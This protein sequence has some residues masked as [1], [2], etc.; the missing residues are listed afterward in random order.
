MERKSLSQYLIHIFE[1]S[2]HRAKK[3]RETTTM[4]FDE[5]FRI[6]FFRESPLCLLCHDARPVPAYHPDGIFSGNELF[7]VIISDEDP[8]D[9]LSL[10]TVISAAVQWMLQVPVAVPS[11][12]S[13]NILL[14]AYSQ[15]FMPQS[16]HEGNLCI[17]SPEKTDG[18]TSRKRI[19]VYRKTLFI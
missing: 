7:P 19:A 8:F 13:I 6:D 12:Y 11:S 18:V 17:S 14:E 9:R 10:R 15:R 5:F 4:L 1:G 16:G 2:L 3:G